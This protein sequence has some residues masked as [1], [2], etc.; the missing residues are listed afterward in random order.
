HPVPIDLET[1][2]QLSS[3]DQ[4]PPEPE[5]AAFDAATEKLASSVM[6]TGLLPAYGRGPDGKVFAMGGVT[7]D[8]NAKIKI[9]REHINSDDMRPPR[10]KDIVTS[11]PNLPHTNGLYAKFSDHIE[12][13]IAG[14]DAYARFLLEK[15]KS[16][17]LFDGFSGLTVRKVVR[18]TRF[19][20][21]LLQRLKNHK[22]MRDGVIW[23]AQ[24]DF[25]ARLADWD[26]ADDPLWPVQRPERSALLALNVPHFV[27]ATDGHE[28]KDAAGFRLRM[29]LTDGLARASARFASL[30]RD[31]IDWQVKVIKINTNSLVA[32]GR[33]PASTARRQLPEL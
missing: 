8:W 12:E 6:A 13:L 14:F 17:A 15:G 18:A 25:V 22:M 23:S 7:A 3:G 26:A 4:K 20:A 5:D 10:W 30:D 21:M 33:P 11:N 31:E 9:K 2:L 1:I 29:P 32:A 16:A 27:V 19:Y 24:A 28:L